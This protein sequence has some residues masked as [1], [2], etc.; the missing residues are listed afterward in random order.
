[1]PHAERTSR[2]CVAASP[3]K[4]A[5]SS[6]ACRPIEQDSPRRAEPSG[7][8]GDGGRGARGR[9]LRAVESGACRDRVADPAGHRDDRLCPKSGPLPVRQLS[10]ARRQLERQPA[11]LQPT[12]GLRVQKPVRSPAEGARARRVSLRAGQLREDGPR[13]GDD[14]DRLG[15]LGERP[16]PSVPRARRAM[17]VGNGPS[18]R[19]RVGRHPE[20]CNL[21]RAHPLSLADGPACLDSVL[22]ERGPSRTER[23]PPGFR[24]S[25]S[26]FLVERS[27][28]STRSWASTSWTRRSSR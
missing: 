19:R 14:L 4:R 15:L 9:R 25:S 28:R 16:G 17:A 1:M 13:T 6:N 8:V 27:P 5:R 7:G 2:A 21:L 24:S 23:A 22:C 12:A 20:L 3:P 26:R 10:R 11:A 18:G